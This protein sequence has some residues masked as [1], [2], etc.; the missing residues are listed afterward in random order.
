M[1]GNIR[2]Q[3]YDDQWKDTESFQSFLSRLQN[4][5]KQ[6]EGSTS[7][8][9]DAMLRTRIIDALPPSLHGIKL[10]LYGSE[11]QSLQHTIQVINDAQNERKLQSESTSNSA[12]TTSN[13]QANSTEGLRPSRR[14]RGRQS[15]RGGRGRG[16]GN[17]RGRGQ[18]RGRGSWSRGW[19][20]TRAQGYHNFNNELPECYNCGQEGHLARGCVQKRRTRNG[21]SSSNAND[22]K[23]QSKSNMQAN[24]VT[25]EP[26]F[27]SWEAYAGLSNPQVNVTQSTS[28]ANDQLWLLDG[29]ASAHITMDRNDLINYTPFTPSYQ[30]QLGNDA[31]L[32]SPGYGDVQLTPR[33]RLKNVW[34]VPGMR[35]KLVAQGVL[36]T[37]YNVKIQLGDPTLLLDDKGVLLAVAKDINNVD[38]IQAIIPCKYT[39]QV[40]YAIAGNPTHP[41]D[42]SA[43]ITS[44][45]ASA[46][47]LSTESEKTA[48]LQE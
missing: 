48:T 39:P 7:A 3:F 4:Y 12:Q 31:L 40:D 14:Q 25:A 11:R 5:K 2:K 21:N 15:S 19:S 13:I 16:R 26:A 32:T 33:L 43:D 45:T 41:S 37:R 20:S 38:G 9:N 29:A 23:Q 46:T 47:A 35:R 44:T 28:T 17:G 10:A 34:W 18:G 30:I 1:R 24:A 36:R 42:S 6:L 27:D 8:I 22:N